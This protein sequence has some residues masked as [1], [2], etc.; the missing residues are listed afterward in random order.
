MHDRLE[1]AKAV[2]GP[3][4]AIPAAAAAR[5]VATRGERSRWTS[6]ILLELRHLPLAKRNRICTDC[7]DSHPRYTQLACASTEASSPHPR[8]DSRPTSWLAEDGQ[9]R[10]PPSTVRREPT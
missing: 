10:T 4:R 5:A 1:L 9:A 3:A 8:A 2:T 7:A 6:H